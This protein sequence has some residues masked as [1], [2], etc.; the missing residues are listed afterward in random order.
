MGKWANKIET[1]LY[2]RIKQIGGVTR[3]YRSP[4]HRGVADRLV[5]LP[6]GKMVIVEI[7]AAGDHEDS[8]QERERMKMIALGFNAVVVY[9]TKD[10]DKL[11]PS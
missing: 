6:G 3:P 9:G 1:Y 5:F 2:Q 7:K 10:I 8:A 4:N 11:F